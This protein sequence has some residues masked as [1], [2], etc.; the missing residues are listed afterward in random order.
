[1][2]C[3]YLD[4]AATTKPDPSVVEAMMPYLRESFYNPSAL[5]QPAV[6][7][8]TRISEARSVTADLIHTSPS[9][10]FFTS[11]GTESDNWAI[12][13]AC[14]L[15]KEKGRHIITSSVEHPAVLRTLK[16]LESQGY[17]VTYLPVDHTGLVDVDDLKR[18]IRKDTVL[19]SVM[20]ANNEIGTVEPIGR[21]GSIA[22]ERGILFHIDAVQTFGHVPVDV[23]AV[24][25]DFLSA[26]SHK[27]YGPKGC[28]FL[29]V[30]DPA[31]FGKLLYG[32]SQENGMRPGT[33]N[34]PAIIG[35]GEASRIAGKRLEEDMKHDEELREILLDELFEN[36]RDMSV[37]G[38]RDHHLPGIVNVTFPGI[39]SESLLIVLDGNGICASAG[40]A[41]ASGAVEP[42]HVL[43]ACGMSKEDASCSVR[44]S[45]G[46]EN[47]END[48]ISTARVI[49][50]FIKGRKNV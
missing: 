29:Y 7:V 49:G 36:V 19:I 39:S 6:K 43:T 27:I 32:G 16:A 4:H 17:E 37:N 48:M 8:R 35:F 21:I 50:E 24:G 25:A 30:K 3:I 34:V 45:I 20:H 22:N 31:S 33:E 12:R 42:S 11:G 28:G 46:R 38:N 40:S 5:Y 18:K 9:K 26:S 44:F 10:I 15:N 47:T 14:E 1:M 41:C 2:N 23:S 13:L